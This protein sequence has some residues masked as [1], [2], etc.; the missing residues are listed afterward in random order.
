MQRVVW[1]RVWVLRVEK[2]TRINVIS[3]MRITGTCLYA[4]KAPVKLAMKMP[5]R[6]NIIGIKRGRFMVN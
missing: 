5:V 3:V 6:K 2:S 4:G 1:K